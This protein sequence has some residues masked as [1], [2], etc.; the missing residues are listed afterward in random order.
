MSW[1]GKAVMLLLPLVLVS[2]LAVVAVKY[3]MRLHFTELQRQ[4][5]TYDTIAVEWSRL[6]LEENTW[7]AH[8]RIERLARKS[9]KLQVPNQQ[10]IIYL[11]P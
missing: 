5:R 9:L 8:G 4:L 1:E 3:S 7:S 11:K 10:Q 6:Q 2:A